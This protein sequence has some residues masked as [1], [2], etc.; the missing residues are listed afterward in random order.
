M[1][2]TGYAIWYQKSKANP[3]A[4]TATGYLVSCNYKDDYRG[5]WEY[6]PVARYLFE[7]GRAVMMHRNYYYSGC[8]NTRVLRY[9][10]GWS[11]A[12]SQF[13]FIGKHS[14][15]N[16]SLQS[17]ESIRE[18]VKDT[19]F[20]YSTWDKFISNNQ[21]MIEFFSVYSK[22]P[23]IE[24]L[25][26]M[27]MEDLVSSMVEGRSLHRSI[28]LRGKTMQNI[29]G[30]SKQEIKD[31]KRAGIGMSPIILH[32]YKWFRKL[33]IPVTWEFA[34]S[35]GHLL[36]GSYY[37]DRL[38]QI[39]SYLS[40][41]EIVRYTQ[42]QMKK[43]PVRRPSVTNILVEWSDYLGECAELGMD[44]ATEKVLMPNNLHKAHQKTSRSIKLKRDEEV[45][46]KI[47]Q[48]QKKL[49]RFM[50]EY[51]G[52]FIRP[53]SSSE[54]LFD[55]GKALDHCVARYSDRYASGDIAILF[56]RRTEFPDVSFYTLELDQRTK[57]IYQCRGLKNND[58]TKEV[59]AFIDV[60]KSEKLAKK[61][62]ERKVAV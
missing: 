34:H 50:F 22:Y 47:E 29:L 44:L 17:I 25:S 11:F 35:C 38:E 8:Y 40:L 9:E 28:N 61:S 57:A 56:I 20:R 10:N 6:T 16:N 45:N 23:F 3:E 27:G 51:N 4:I 7:T 39:K 18:A 54:E 48:Q 15:T 24:Y 5:V 52:L 58:P 53:A 55:E 37:L 26:K 33:G 59:Q 19:P 62:K 13:S 41:E 46:R 30:L 2:D 43:D 42:N 14:Y 1:L 21:D 60:F 12:K 36:D 49:Q 31:W 32:T